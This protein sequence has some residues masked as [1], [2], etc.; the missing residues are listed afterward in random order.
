MPAERATLSQFISG[1]TVG[2]AGTVSALPVP[3]D[4]STC[5]S[6]CSAAIACIPVTKGSFSQLQETSW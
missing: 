6:W 2:A 3:F 4:F 5:S 1:G